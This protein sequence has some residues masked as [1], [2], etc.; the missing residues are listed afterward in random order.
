MDGSYSTNGWDDDDG[1]RSYYRTTT[2]T[3]SGITD[4]YSEWYSSAAKDCLSCS[5]QYCVLPT[6]YFKRV[7]RRPANTLPMLLGDP[8]PRP[9]IARQTPA[10]DCIRTPSAPAPTIHV[11]IWRTSRW[12]DWLIEY[13]RDRHPGDASP[14][15]DHGCVVI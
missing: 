10:L 6:W 13:V 3:L 7:G 14:P 8:L 9:P 5:A 2:R 4:I 12:L 1:A 11:R 15:C